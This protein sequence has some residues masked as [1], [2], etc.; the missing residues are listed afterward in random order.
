MIWVVNIIKVLIQQSDYQKAR[1]YWKVLKHRLI[2]EGGNQTVTNCNRLK[3]LSDDDKFR[4]TDCANCRNY[5][6][7]R[8]PKKEAG[9]QGGT[10]AKNARV[11]LEKKTGKKVISNENN[12]SL[13]RIL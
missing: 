2:Q 8:N 4:E 1:N 3:L 9:K 7:K 6:C 11:E 13:K 5:E 10:V 12:L